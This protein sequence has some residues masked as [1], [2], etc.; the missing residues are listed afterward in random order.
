MGSTKTAH[1]PKKA[2]LVPIDWAGIEPHY[3]A[4]IRSVASIAKQFGCSH[5]AI[6]KHAKKCGWVRSLKPAILERADQLVTAKAA[7]GVT[8]GVTAG[9]GY[10]DAQT[11]EVNAQALAIVQHAHR[12]VAADE[13][14][15]A[16][17]FLGELMVGALE[18]EVFVR[19][20]DLL[21]AL[22]DEPSPE[23][24]ADM[25]EAMAMLANLPGRVKV[26]KDLVEL[27]AKIIGMEREAYGLN[28]EDGTGRDRFTVII[29]DYTGRGD[30]DSPRALE[31][32]GG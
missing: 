19:V 3:K 28:T 11:I 14:V 4:G 25:R 13:R 17:Q 27:T 9:S 24:K 15:L 10:S 29:K 5:V 26:L 21:E 6:L 7:S 12:T 16:K 22:D 23:Q 20:R 8:A 1:K 18:P 31:A 2:D 32:A 30:P